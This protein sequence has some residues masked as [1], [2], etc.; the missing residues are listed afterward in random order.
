MTQKNYNFSKYKE[1]DKNISHHNLKLFL[2][3]SKEK[4]INC[5]LLFGTLLGFYRDGKFISE[6]NDTDIGCIYEEF[7]LVETDFLKYL[8]LLGF[9]IFRESNS[10]IQIVKDDNHIDFYLFRKLPCFNGRFSGKFYISN[11]HF[12]KILTIKC[13]S[14]QLE[15]PILNKTDK[16]LTKFYGRN[17]Q[18]PLK[19]K[20]ASENFFL[21]IM[22][23]ILPIKILKLIQKI[24]K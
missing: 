16:L 15:Y 22:V 5:F 19:G 13:G 4:R 6:D 8:T 9:K 23:K 7:E 17:W 20:T 18:I 1:L 10:L 24:L 21:S 3:I 11:D 12:K 2:K 14:D